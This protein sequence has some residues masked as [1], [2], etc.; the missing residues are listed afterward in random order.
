MLTKRSQVFISAIFQ[1]ATTLRIIPF[2][3]NVKARH[4][5][6]LF[7]LAALPSFLILLL[8]WANSIYVLG[9]LYRVRKLSSV[10]ASSMSIH[11]FLLVSAIISAIFGYNNFRRRTEIAS[12]INQFLRF[13][14]H[15][16][17]KMTHLNFPLNNRYLDIFWICSSILGKGSC[18]KK[19]F[20]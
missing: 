19:E 5:S 11:V 13:Q 9:S 6:P 18:S 15:L 2:N 4:L 17:G 1:Q 20:L 14:N 7:G 3:W 8:I 16:E 10:S 12:F